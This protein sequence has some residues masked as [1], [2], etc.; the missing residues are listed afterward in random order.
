MANESEFERWLSQLL[1]PIKPENGEAKYWARIGKYY[2]MNRTIQ[3]INEVVSAYPPDIFP[4]DGESLDCKSASM[5]RHICGLICLRLSEAKE[6]E[7]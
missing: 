2:E 5:A 3:V 7:G 4:E 1:P 6:N